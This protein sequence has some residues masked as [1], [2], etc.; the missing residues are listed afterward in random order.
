MAIAQWTPGQDFLT[1]RDAMNRLFEESFWSPSQAQ[2]RAGQAPVDV[3]TEGDDFV[4]EVALPGM[5][6]DDINI[7]MVGNSLTISGEVKSEAPEGRAY[8][9]RQ[10]QVGKFETSLTLPDA[11]DTAR[12]EA[13]Y[14]H[15]VLRLRVPKSEAAKP[16]RITVQ[17]S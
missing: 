11:A 1:L 15:G 2:A 3:Y 7:Q 10:R 8:L 13:S 12:A 4:I 17:A 14:E 9:M 16:K 5:R 6:P